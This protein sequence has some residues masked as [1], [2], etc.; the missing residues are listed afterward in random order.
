MMS[1]APP[2]R[3][4][5]WF[6]FSL[7]SLLIFV[8]VAGVWLGQKANRA[9]K[10]SRAVEAIAKWGGTV[11]FDYESEGLKQPAYPA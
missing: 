8:A 11:N 10:Q 4:R 1:Q 3:R 5:R 6:R 9:Q 7:R 2:K